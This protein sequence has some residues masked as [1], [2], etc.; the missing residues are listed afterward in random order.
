M[1][2]P[3]IMPVLVQILNDAGVPSPDADYIAGL[4]APEMGHDLSETAVDLLVRRNLDRAVGVRMMAA[5]Q[6]RPADVPQ[7]LAT[8]YGPELAAV[9]GIPEA[10][11]RALIIGAG[12]GIQDTD[13]AVR[14]GVHPCRTEDDRHACGADGSGR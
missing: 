5:A 1:L 4:L 9:T 14:P 13:H 8:T 3:Q 11:A 6:T 10:D 2:A 7:L 12:E